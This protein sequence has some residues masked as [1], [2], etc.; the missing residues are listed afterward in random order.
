M[1]PYVVADVFTD[2]PLE[3]N[4]VAVFTAGQDVPSDQMQA[5]ARELNLSETVFVLPPEADGDA[6]VRIFTPAMELPFAGHPI[7]GTAYVLGQ[8]TGQD[9][10][11]LET[12]NGTVPVSLT[13]QDGRIVEGRMSQPIPTWEVYQDAAEL[14]AALGVKYSVLPVEV[15]TNGPRHLYIAVDTT[16]AVASLRPNLNALAALPGIGVSCFAGSGTQ[17][18]TRMFG[19]SLGVAE[20]PATGSAAGPLGVHLARHGR[21]PFGQEIEL[22]QGAEIGRP[23]TLRVRIEGEGERIDRVEVAGS[24]VIVSRGELEELR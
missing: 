2:R 13:R 1:H 6:R 3:G 23:S 19:P 22:S 8:G 18:K 24:A 20:D 4:P 14:L 7:L 17:W 11:R 12:G 10:I 9:V 5:I 21:I 15:Y 16:D